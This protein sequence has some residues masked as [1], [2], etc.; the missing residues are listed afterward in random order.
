MVIINTISIPG[1]IANAIINATSHEKSAL[2]C[3]SK[4]WRKA[5]AGLQSRE[6]DQILKT[7]SSLGEQSNYFT[8]DLKAPIPCRLQAIILRQ[9]AGWLDAHAQT[10]NT[11]SLAN[12]PTFFPDWSAQY[13]TYLLYQMKTREGI[14][15]EKLSK[16]DLSKQLENADK[17]Y[18]AYRY[19]I[20]DPN[21]F[22]QLRK[23][24]CELLTP[25]FFSHYPPNIDR[26]THVTSLVVSYGLQP[27]PNLPVLIQTCK[28]IISYGSDIQLHAF[29][30]SLGQLRDLG[31]QITLFS[32]LKQSLECNRFLA[33]YL[34]VKLLLQKLS[35]S[36]TD[37]CFRNTPWLHISK[38]PAIH[39][40]LR[41]KIISRWETVA[42]EEKIAVEAL[43]ELRSAQN[44]EYSQLYEAAM[45]GGTWTVKKMLKQ[46]PSLMSI[47]DSHGRTLFHHVAQE[48]RG[49]YV[50]TIFLAGVV[51]LL[52]QKGADVDH[53]DFHGQTA[54]RLLLSNPWISSGLRQEVI[55]NMPESFKEN[56]ANTPPTKRR[57]KKDT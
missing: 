55:Q 21:F 13:K 5:V 32:A 30:N 8:S 49:S 7:D 40:F 1:D 26:E 37:T 29:F 48:M 52:M 6:Y 20:L 43:L 33:V 3:V 46:S 24:S 12:D 57:K 16:D 15:V 14:A 41:Q 36:I 2:A 50:K 22:E 44:L 19:L 28:N 27:Q 53:P 51:S 47:V 9:F 11:I 34:S 10:S 42:P 17:K 25:V 39:R 18:S 56:M 4:A 38:D 31:Q 35:Q 54:G 23:K 45:N